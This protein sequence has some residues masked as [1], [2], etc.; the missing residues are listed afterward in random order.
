MSIATD[1]ADELR[2]QIAVLQS[3]LSLLEAEDGKV[4]KFV[5]SLKA[6]GSL[7]DLPSVEVIAKIVDRWIKFKG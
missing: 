4:M 2:A 1:K 7:P 5:D 3:K 6:D